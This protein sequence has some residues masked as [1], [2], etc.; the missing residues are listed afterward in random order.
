[1]SHERPE[2]EA[3]LSERGYPAEAIAKIMERLDRFDDKVN[4]DSLFDAI[5]TG[6]VDMD[7][8]IKEALAE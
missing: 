6:E 8:L 1:M 7:A 5:S 2:I 4:R 3:W